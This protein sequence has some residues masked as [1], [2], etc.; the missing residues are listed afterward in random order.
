MIRTTLIFTFVCLAVI[1][2]PVKAQDLLVYSSGYGDSQTIDSIK[3]KNLSTSESVSL[4]GQ[5]VLELVPASASR[6]LNDPDQSIALY[7]NPAEQSCR[8]EMEISEEQDACIEIY[9]ISGKLLL[10]HCQFFNKAVHSFDIN[11]LGGGVYYFS[12]ISNNERFTSKLISTSR[13]LPELSLQYQGYYQST[14]NTIN[15]RDL[16]NNL[17][18]AYNYGDIILF[19][20]NSVEGHK[21]IKTLI[22]NEE[23]EILNSGE[24][25]LNFWFFNCSDPLGNQYSIVEIGDQIWMADNLNSNLYSDTSSITE[26]SDKEMWITANSGAYC[27]YENTSANAVNMGKLYNWFAVN[28]TKGL[29]PEGWHIPSDAEWAEL[30]MYLGLNST[31]T[32]VVGWRGQMQ[33]NMLKKSGTD[34][35]MSQSGTHINYTGFSAK[36]GGIRNFAGDFYYLNENASWWTSTESNE[37]N[38]WC[39]ALQY[40]KNNI[41][42]EDGKKTMG[43]SVRCIKSPVSFELPETSIDSVYNVTSTLAEVSGNVVNDG[44]NSVTIRGFVW[45]TNQNP[46]ISNNIGISENG[47]GIGEYSYTITGLNPN[48]TYY[49]RAYASNEAG[50]A[51]SQPRSFNTL[52]LLYTQGD[53]L[54]DIDD[55]EYNTIV[56]NGKEWMAE[57]LRATNY[58]DNTPITRISTSA[59]W[60]DNLGDAYCWYNHDSVANSVKYGALYNWLT[61]E[62]EK[63]CPMGWHIPDS[64]EWVNLIEFLGGEETAGAKMKEEGF[65]NW[66]TPNTG[67]I[68]TS[69]LTIVPAGYCEQDGFFLN[70]GIE[71]F[72]WTATNFDNFNSYELSLQNNQTSVEL[73]T[74]NINRGLSV[75]CVKNDDALPILG[76]LPVS[77]IT[78][79]TSVCGGNIL[80]NGGYNITDKGLVWHTSS[81]PDLS[82][83]S[84]FTSN[85]T[86]LASFSKRI[87]G[88]DPETTYYIKA[89]ASNEE[90]TSYGEEQ[91]F[92][93]G[94]LLFYEGSGAID[95]DNNEYP[96]VVVGDQEWM[97]DNIRTSTYRDGTP[98]ERISD[99]TDWANQTG[100]AY[101]WYNNDSIANDSTYSKLYNWYAVNSG[102]LCPY[103]WHVAS[104]DEWQNMIDLIGEPAMAGAFMKSTG[105]LESGTGLWH[106]P[107]SGANNESGFNGF[108]GGL[109]DEN[110]N[111]DLMNN[112]GFW[113][114]TSPGSKT[115]GA[116]IGLHHDT[117]G[118]EISSTNA[119]KGFS[120]RCIKNDYTL[121]AVTIIDATNITPVSATINCEVTDNG[122][123][124]VTERGIIWSLNSDPNMEVNDGIIPNGGG[125][126][127]FSCDINGLN[128]GTTYFVKAYAINDAGITYSDE[129]S[130]NTPTLLYTPGDGVYDIDGNFYNSIIINGQEIMSENLRTSSYKDGS[131]IEKVED[132]AMWSA[133]MVGAYCWYN[134]DSLSYEAIYGKLYNHLVVE[135]DEVCPTG[136]HIITED[137][138]K[139]LEE[140]LGMPVSDLDLTG[141]RGEF[142]GGKL[143]EIGTENWIDPNLDAINTSGYTA[144][145]SG[146]REYDGIFYDEGTDYYVWTK[147]FDQMN[148]Y[149]R[150]LNYNQNMSYRNTYLMFQDNESA[151]GYSIRCVKT[152]MSLAELNTEPVTNITPY[153]AQ[154]GG[155]IS[156]DGNGTITARGIVWSTSNGPTIDVNEGITNDG[157]EVGSF[158]SELN[159][160]TPG[161]T[162]YVRAYA[163]NEEGT[164]YGNEEEFTT[165]LLLYSPGSGV[166]DYDGNFYNTVIVD[167]VEFMSENLRTASYNQGGYIERVTDAF[168]WSNTFDGAYCWYN[169]DSLNYE[170][171]Y[172][173]LYNYA[174]VLSGELCPSTWHV[175]TEEDFASLE[176]FLGMDPL[177]LEVLGWRG[178][179]IGGMLKET[180]TTN[181]TDPNLGASNISGYSAIPS[182]YRDPDGNFH[183]INNAYYTWTPDII[184]DFAGMRKLS[185]DQHM[186]MRDD[187]Y[188]NTYGER[189]GYAVRCVKTII[190]LAELSTE[191]VTDITPFT[192]TSGGNITSNGN[193][194]I[195]ARGVVWSTSPNPTIGINEG[196]TD[197]GQGDG[198]FISTIDGLT[199]GTTY[200]LR[201]FAFNEEGAAYGNEEVFTTAVLLY[202]P[203]SGV[204]DYD[205]NFY[206]TVIVDGVEFMSENLR[207]S[208][209]N[210]GG[211]INRVTDAFTWSSMYDPAFCWYND[212]SLNYEVPYGKLYN[213]SAVQSGGLCPVGWHIMSDEEFSLLEVYLGLNE[214]ESNSIGW[215]GEYI[216]GKLKEIGT[217]FWMTPN[218]DAVNTSGYSA[219]PT[220]YRE[221][222][223]IFYDEGTAFYAWTP[224]LYT[225][226]ATMRKLS[227]DQNMT[228]RD[229]EYMNTNGEMRGYSVRCVKSDLTLPVVIMQTI[230]YLS[231]FD[232]ECD[233]E[234]I[235]D[236]YG[237]ITGKGFVWSTSPDPTIMLNEGFTDEGQGIGYFMSYISPLTPETVYYIRAYATN[238][239]GTSYS[240]QEMIYTPSEEPFM[241][242]NNISFIYNNQ[243]VTYGTVQYGDLCWLDRDLGANAVPITINDINGYGDLFQWGREDD[244]HQ[245]RQSTVIN[246]QAP[247]NNQPGH[248]FFIYNE[249]DVLDWN[250]EHF[251]TERWAFIDQFM[252]YEEIFPACPCPDGWRPPTPGEWQDAIMFEEWNNATDAFNSPLKLC[253][254]GERNGA[255]GVF[256]EGVSASF[257]SAN[258]NI[259]NEGQAPAFYMDAGIVNMSDKDFSKGFSVRCILS[260]PQGGAVNK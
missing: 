16:K 101:C 37:A 136:W 183:D 179:Q 160:L 42:R 74:G 176:L 19:E 128:A 7:P 214:F 219:L 233:G 61:V 133:G 87:T 54:I 75:R 51:Y 189:K 27:N 178:E 59:D 177:E 238:E 232:A 80:D 30:E 94:T 117:T 204:T 137:E 132:N 108:P 182:G 200:Y 248:N 216:G 249:N 97:S 146:Y 184:N 237:T 84:G 14:E 193:G 1:I 197:D 43:F 163:T 113:W 40:D 96:S 124:P 252:G 18:L 135:M 3:V 110:G 181:W 23:D 162:Y 190:N 153:A 167:G 187:E 120:V 173:K 191:P 202:T 77:Q 24:L 92:T 194:T 6:L 226:A 39:R 70:S 44:G 174:A 205:G 65:E 170:V 251:W 11:G 165:A 230:A 15:T 156:S 203:G 88:L 256:N 228:Y 114:S 159:G 172:G 89:Y 8:V 125:L 22:I 188:M 169:D 126:G 99:P 69:G 130:F 2:S 158:I 215:R 213:L 123:N 258:V 56:L 234:V 236:G 185:Y 5:D 152:I 180:G 38:A 206:N 12:L 196:M 208:N 58:K 239:E 68:N 98:I 112:S 32:S 259:G 13:A 144:L 33:G 52:A 223:G 34:F 29:C 186:S 151:R 45:G 41:F 118:V 103:G 102:K 49:I 245:D 148:V 198:S 67:A 201:A 82:N 149:M 240:N 4:S 241:C 63:I 109:R 161:T 119:I 253:L 25:A 242:G 47:E 129:T 143:K 141:W 168:T 116:F 218:L 71:S 93:T 155:F 104:I 199:P 212:D 227:Y 157:Q 175:M 217:D 134:N 244:G 121:P 235:N 81:N 246:I 111:F 9:D 131:P 64:A 255:S 57:N 122:G 10:K 139:E 55:N 72:L 86:G 164:A 62:T 115:E 50:T 48:T 195:L 260:D 35:W 243:L 31:S 231:P 140:F 106:L 107:N 26:I 138:F 85:G 207:T 36:P 83:N 145:P 171:P 46:D 66:N 257:W 90:G 147:H 95:P 100:G 225:E 91:T 105:T 210:E 20:A 209:L 192:A 21:T 60:V 254:G 221:H 150:S 247:A 222:D 78:A 224:P 166:T 127:L 53:G 154:S 17:I 73:S 79:T 229:D 211:F 220:G 76:T 142:V 250:V 28:N